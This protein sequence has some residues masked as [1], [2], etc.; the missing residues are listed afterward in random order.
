MERG[1]SRSLHW[2]KETFRLS[3]TA[4]IVASF[5]HCSVSLFI[6]YILPEC[7]S[8]FP[9]RYMGV[10]IAYVEVGSLFPAYMDRSVLHPMHSNNSSF[11][12]SNGPGRGVSVLEGD[13]VLVMWHCLGIYVYNCS[14]L[15]LLHYGSH[16]CQVEVELILPSSGVH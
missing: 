16:P 2:E 3:S 15:L 9:F 8:L 6:S 4:Q 5:S 7:S 11:T 10:C 14:K 12:L 13:E 1:N